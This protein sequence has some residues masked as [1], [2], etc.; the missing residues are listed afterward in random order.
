ME[1]AESRTSVQVLAPVDNSLTENAYHMQLVILTE[2]Y[3]KEDHK[4][5]KKQ[6]VRYIQNKHPSKPIQLHKEHSCN[7]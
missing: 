2:M 4:R 6:F 7:D 5:K 3:H 1:E